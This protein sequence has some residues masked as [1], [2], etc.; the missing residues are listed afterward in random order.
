MLRSISLSVVFLISGALG[1]AVAE[2]RWESKYRSSEGT[3]MD[4]SLRSDA[5]IAISGRGKYSTYR[6]TCRRSSDREL[7]CSGR[8]TRTSDNKVYQATYRLV[9]PD[10]GKTLTS[11]WRAVYANGEVFNGVTKLTRISTT[12]VAARPKPPPP[13]APPPV[14]RG[15]REIAGNYKAEGSRETM[16]ISNSGSDPFNVEIELGTRAA[17]VSGSWIPGQVGTGFRFKVDGTEYTGIFERS[18]RLIF[19]R[20]AGRTIGSF[21]RK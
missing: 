12:D 7:A 1:D 9:S 18:S 16:R 2:G 11:T 21:K 14:Y 17:L 6:A 3:T 10:N 5:T 8:G 13:P 15:T 20:K 4:I 19:I